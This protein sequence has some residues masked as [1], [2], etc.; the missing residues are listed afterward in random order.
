VITF[1][2]GPTASGKSD[3]AIKEA[4]RQNGIIVNADSVQI[5]KHLDIGSAKPSAADR[6]LVPHYLYDIV[7]PNEDFTAG[8]FRRAALEVIEKNKNRPI[9][10]VGGSGFYIQALEKGMYELPKISADKKSEILLTLDKWQSAEAL[11]SELGLRDPVAAKR[12]SPNDAYRVRRALE[13]I[14]TTGR[15][16]TEIEDE[17]KLH[18]KRLA[19]DYEVKKIGFKVPRT[20]LRQRVTDRTRIMLK[21]GFLDEVRGLIDKGFAQ[22]KALHSV[23]YRECVAYLA[24]QQKSERFVAERLATERL[25]SEIVTSTMQ[26]AKK[27][28]TWFRRDPDI[29]WRESIES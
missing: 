21:N 4:Q 14:L 9:F 26:L 1:V 10:F 2:V 7:L 6:L 29:E 19:D 5:Y 25:V 15:K 17:F 20:V 22:T 27:Q 16:M 8:D 3:F 13:I 23:G 24:G 12:L 11:Y 18:S 28:M